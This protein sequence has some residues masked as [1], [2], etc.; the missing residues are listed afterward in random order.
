VRSLGINRFVIYFQ[1]SPNSWDA[2][3][4]NSPHPRE[5][6]VVGDL[7]NNGKVDI[8]G[9]GFIL[10]APT[11][12]RA[13]TVEGTNRCMATWEQKTFD[14]N[15]FN[16]NP[17]GLNNSSKGDVYDM[18]GPSNAKTGAWLRRII[19]EPQGRNHNVQLGDVD[20]DGDVDVLGG[21]SF[22]SRKVFWWENVNGDAITWSRHEINGSRGCYSCVA[23]DYDNDGDIDFAGPTRYANQVY[24]YRNTTADG[25]NI[26]NASPTSVSFTAV[27]GSESVA[28][29][30]KK[31]TDD[32]DVPWTASSN[33]PWLT[34]NATS[35]TGNANV[36]LSAA[37]HSGF[38]NRT[39]VVT[40]SNNAISR[41][42]SVSQLGASDT[43]PPSAPTNLVASNLSFDS[44][45]L[46]WDASSD[47]SNQLIE[48][49]VKINLSEEARTTELSTNITGLTDSTVYNVQL[50]AIDQSGNESAVSSVINVTTTARPPS[51]PGLVDTTK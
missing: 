46:S 51:P 45:T 5:G 43:T 14:A 29:T 37:Q 10:F 41:N 3:R 49:R 16:A 38:G 28:I 24:L 20:L 42:I 2:V 19:E 17:S 9:N 4:I 32:S 21:F 18:D 48:Y 40:V 8:I 15:F 39:A 22:G 25:S 36:L 30:S 27:G 12:P 33:Q 7:D 35:G 34:L 6:L 50:T 44:F 23:A 26:L 31:I 1:N 13:C 47:N 11:N